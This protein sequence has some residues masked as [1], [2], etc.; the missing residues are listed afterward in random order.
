VI[1]NSPFPGLDAEFTLLPD[2]VREAAARAPERPA[3]IDAAGGVAVTYATLAARI[4]RVAAGLAERGFAPGDVLAVRAPNMPPWAGVALGAMA[5]GGAVTGISPLASAQETAAQLTDAGAS[6]LVTVPSLASESL[7]AATATAVRDVVV[8]GSSPETAAGGESPPVTPIGDLLACR[9]AAPDTS[10][11]PGDVA[12]LPYS[13][14]TTGLPK[15][16]MLTHANLTAAARQLAGAIGLTP[17]DR[18]L[19]L[20]PFAHVMG[21]WCRCRRRWPRARPW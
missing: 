12:L 15:G 2:L 5:A 3:L 17:R 9:A 11:A 13:S 20:A 18:F 6:V 16:V 10:A 21:S 4:D 1:Y 8:V 7:A 14:G 19:A